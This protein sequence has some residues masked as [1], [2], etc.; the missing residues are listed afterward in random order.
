VP[1]TVPVAVSTWLISAP[2][3]AD[4]P[5]TPDCTTVQSKEAPETLLVKAMDGAVPEQ[6]V[7]EAGVAVATGLGFTVITTLI[8]LPEQLPAVGVIV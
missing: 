5:E 6:R 2:V 4:A 7:C 3:P 1:A 8:G